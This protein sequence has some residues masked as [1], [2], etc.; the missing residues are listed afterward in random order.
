MSKH[1]ISDLHKPRGARA[2]VW[3]GRSCAPGRGVGR[4]WLLRAMAAY[5]LRMHMR[6]LARRATGRGTAELGGFGLE[7]RGGV[8]KG[9]AAWAR[10]CA[11]LGN[12][13]GLY[14]VQMTHIPGARAACRCVKPRVRFANPKFEF[15]SV[16]DPA[17]SGPDSVRFRGRG[18]R[19]RFGF[20]AQEPDPVRFRRSRAGFGSVYAPRNRIRFGLAGSHLGVAP[21]IRLPL[22]SG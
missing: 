22:G 7:Y 8:R 19:I 11:C 20:G 17:I 13:R 9:R 15:G 10:G 1:W 18:G 2:R 12:G 4:L 14:V 3:C 6:P 16:P 5:P 21:W